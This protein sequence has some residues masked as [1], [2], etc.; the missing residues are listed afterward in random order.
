MLPD[1]LILLIA[2]ILISKLCFFPPNPTFLI[3]PGDQEIIETGNA[4]YLSRTS[5]QATA[6]SEKDTEKTLMQLWKV[7]IYNRNKN[8]AWAWDDVTKQCINGSLR[9]DI[10][11]VCL[12]LKR[13]SQVE[14]GAKTTKA[15]AEMAKRS[16]LGVDENNTE[17]LL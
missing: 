8:L 3:Q 6:T 7:Y 14:E 4:Y 13:I 16:N 2:F 12:W 17:E 10:Q 1:I 15:V 5:A 9:E 11:E